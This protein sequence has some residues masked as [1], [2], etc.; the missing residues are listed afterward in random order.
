MARSL[1]LVVVQESDVE[2]LLG[3]NVIPVGTVARLDRRSAC[4]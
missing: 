1:S 2:A 3:M 4:F